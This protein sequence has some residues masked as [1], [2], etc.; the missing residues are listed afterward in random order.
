M[1][2]LCFPGPL[3]AAYAPGICARAK[4][5]GRGW[6]RWQDFRC[7]A[8]ARRP[9]FIPGQ[10]QVDA[11]LGPSVGCSLGVLGGSRFCGAAPELVQLYT[12]L[13][14]KS[15]Q[16]LLLWRA[17]IAHGQLLWL[18]T[19]TSVQAG[20][21]RDTGPPARGRGDI[22]GDQRQKSGVFAALA[23]GMSAWVARD[24]YCSLELSAG[25]IVKRQGF[26]LGSLL[27]DERSGS[28]NV[29][30]HSNHGRTIQPCRRVGSSD[31][32]IVSAKVG[33]LQQQL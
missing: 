2:L 8:L 28:K 31:H 10:G 11:N 22:G 5:K 17:F 23:R 24:L 18:S 1:T 12:E 9:D 15:F 25:A 7:G 3:M 13:G 30:F 6:W 14:T 20:R 27:H 26:S 32:R 33:T 21:V 19:S 16:I 29:C 4:P